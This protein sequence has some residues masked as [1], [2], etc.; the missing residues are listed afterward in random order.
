MIDLKTK[1]EILKSV[2]IAYYF[3]YQ[4]DISI[5]KTQ[6]SYI[7]IKNLKIVVAEDQIKFDDIESTRSTIYHELSHAILTP[8][9]LNSAID[10][11][12]SC[13]PMPLNFERL[14]DFINIFEDQ[15]IE[16]LM[17]CKFLKINFYKNVF[18][19][20]NTTKE[21]ELNKDLTRENF[22]NFIN[23]FYAVV[24][25]GY[26]GGISEGFLELI[27][28]KIINIADS[29]NKII[30][31]VSYSTI[32]NFSNYYYT[33]KWLYFTLKSI[34]EN[35]INNPIKMPKSQEK[36]PL[37]NEKQENKKNE[38]DGQPQWQEAEKENQTKSASPLID[39]GVSEA[40]N[41]LKNQV[42]NQLIINDAQTIDR[43]LEAILRKNN[44]STVASHA[45][46][47]Q[48]AN[49]NVKNY[50]NNFSDITKKYKSFEKKSNAGNIKKNKKTRL[51]FIQD[52]SGSYDDNRKITAGIYRAVERFY[53]KNQNVF[54]YKVYTSLNYHYYLQSYVS[55]QSIL[56]NPLCGGNCLCDNLEQDIKLKPEPTMYNDIYIILYDGKITIDRVFLKSYFKDKKTII[57]SDESNAEAFEKLVKINSHAKLYTLTDR[58]YSSKLYQVIKEA[59]KEVRA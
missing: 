14:Y 42:K 33:F 3:G 11:Y 41:D 28:E 32:A 8:S 30:S 13:E 17:K 48:G 49:F 21:T 22:P 1:E 50:A 38:Q 10:Y 36:I 54:D 35:S 46:N 59:L 18:K 51:I 37:Q 26:T 24:R 27:N 57:V 55:L 15:R 23:Y 29:N 52:I 20:N 45:F 47:Y 31:N 34:Y 53:K 44:G 5:E 2:P 12:I 19:I 58:E 6:T 16:S 7:D 56:S 40:L 39:E 43:E 4:L 25:Y 9:I